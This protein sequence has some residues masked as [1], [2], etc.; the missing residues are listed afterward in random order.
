MPMLLLVLVSCTRPGWGAPTL[1]CPPP[2][3]ARRPCRGRTSTGLEGERGLAET[4]R[5]GGLPWQLNKAHEDG[6]SRMRLAGK[7]C[8]Y[9]EQPW[10]SF[11]TQ[12]ST[13]AGPSHRLGCGPLRPAVSPMR[14]HTSRDH[15]Y[16]VTLPATQQSLQKGSLSKKHP[17]AQFNCKLLPSLKKIQG[18]SAK[19][20]L[21]ACLLRC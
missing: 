6:V 11:Q 18:R 20:V 16:T 8:D 9:R 4:G 19:L 7:N 5:G 3:P 21:R 14:R 13:T 17:A 12:F 15:V 10:S 1:G 2:P